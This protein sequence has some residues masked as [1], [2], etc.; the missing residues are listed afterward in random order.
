MPAQSEA[1]HPFVAALDSRSRRLRTPSDGGEMMWRVWGS[2]PAIV[3][4]HGGH[5]SWTHW[6]RNIAQLATAHTVVIPDMPGYGESDAPATP[7][8][9][10]SLAASIAHGIDAVIG[11]QTPLSIVGFSFGATVGGYVASLRRDHV[12]RLV[13]VGAGGL[14]LPSPKREELRNWRLA[15][16]DEAREVAHRSNLAT[17]MIADPARIDDLAVWVQNENTQR[18]RINSRQFGPR[19]LLA[20]LLTS[21]QVPLAG[22]W[23]A[24][25]ATVIGY[26]DARETLLRELDPAAPFVSIE[27]AG[28]W[29]QYEDPPAFNKALAGALAR[30]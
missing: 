12:R 10:M 4:L 26:L 25:D 29:V 20:K 30:N 2:G 15:R 17:L 5:G 23:G 18:T 21:L 28:H 1:A 22:I 6:V 19:N 3:L 27:G 8:T 9:P 14:A 11:R 7:Y 16:S 13:L 24:R